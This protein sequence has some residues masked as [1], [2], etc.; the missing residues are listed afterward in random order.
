MI[1]LESVFGKSKEYFLSIN[2]QLNKCASNLRQ[3][4]L[5]FRKTVSGLLGLRPAALCKA[6]LHPGTAVE[7]AE[8]HLYDLSLTDV[9]ECKIHRFSHTAWKKSSR[10]IEILPSVSLLIDTH[11]SIWLTILPKIFLSAC[12]ENGAVLEGK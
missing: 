2:P 12:K 10:H 5:H 9:K 4:L 6:I 7:L 3:I 11:C 8:F 1:S